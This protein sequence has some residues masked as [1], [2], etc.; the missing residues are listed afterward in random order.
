MATITW[1][2][3]VVGTYNTAA[4]WSGGVVPGAK[5]TAVV[6]SAGDPA[7][8]LNKTDGI[9]SPA[10]GSSNPFLCGLTLA[11]ATEK[12]VTQPNG[13]IWYY[14][15]T[16]Q[17]SAVPAGE[18]IT[19]A[20]L[21]LIG[22]GSE[23][24]LALQNST[25]AAPTV[26]NVSGAAYLY[27]G[28]T[29]ALKGNIDIGLPFSVNGKP[30]T[31]AGKDAN[32]FANALYLD[33]QGYGS[34]NYA[35]TLNKYTASGYVPATT[36]TGTITVG[37]GS[38]LFVSVNGFT[39][40]EV[41]QGKNTIF[42]PPTLSEFVN[43]GVITVEAGGTLH[44]AASGGQG[45][46][47]NFG[48]IA[49]DGGAGLTTSAPIQAVV[50]GTGT[51][52]LSGGSQTSAA[53]TYAEIVNH[54]TGQTFRISDATLWINGGSGVSANNIAVSGGSVDFVGKNGVLLFSSAIDRPP[55]TFF[56]DSIGGFAP[57][58]TIALYIGLLPGE[59]WKLVP[60]WTAG[61][62]GGTLDLNG[63]VTSIL[64][65]TTTL[66][67]ALVLKGAYPGGLSDFAVH[68][69]ADVNGLATVTVATSV[70]QAAAAHAPPPDFHPADWHMPGGGGLPHAAAA[71]GLATAEWAALAHV[72]WKLAARHPGAVLLPHA[73]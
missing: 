54:V 34:W 70:S 35:A 60:S 42:T 57:T 36:S 1:K 17:K 66:E 72:D 4:D 38:A 69:S 43:R 31:S 55:S 25:I 68:A 67:A 20:A 51:W 32:G 14:F 52:S 6:S 49:I 22:G 73:A 65:T 13:D 39:A 56:S 41:P 8:S 24:A 11:T 46:L 71:P 9:I 12:S 50:Q 45:V 7:P 19:A 59:N 3:G 62:G 53:K 21:D 26:T 63:V 29:N 61:S 40:G 28:Y 37:A 48:T 2:N 30:V 27:A 15:V 33:V 58:D 16:P 64:G 10:S 23:A 5:D 44:V 47:A 18:T